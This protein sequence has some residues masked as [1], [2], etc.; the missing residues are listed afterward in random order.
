MKTI[1]KNILTPLVS[2]LTIMCAVFP[3]LADDN[4][5]KAKIGIQIKSKDKLTRAKSK[6]F[7]KPGDY[8]RIYVKPMQISYVYAVY[9]DG[10]T[11]SLLNM[12][13]QK[14]DK[15]TGKSFLFLPSDK[16]FYKVDGAS[17]VERF[18]VICSLT[19]VQGISGM[20]EAG[21]PHEKWMAIETELMKKSKITLVRNPESPIAIAGNVRG[22]D[23]PEDRE[24]FVKNLPIYSGKGLVVKKYEFHIK[25]MGK[26]QLKK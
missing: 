1:R 5:V 3:A 16:A 17:P 22:I 11:A 23:T 6:E 19:E 14:L 7:I 4:L 13:M 18:S 25:K 15:D 24:R 20:N 26:K 2:A 10:K 8:I 21:I 9:S 12:T